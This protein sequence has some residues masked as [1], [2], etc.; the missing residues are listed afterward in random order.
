MGTQYKELKEKDKLFI[1]KQK[2]FYVASSSGQEVNLSPK[3]Y[4]SI[5][6]LDSKT[7]LYLDFPGSG[8]RTGRD[9]ENDGE[10]T[11]V[12]NSFEESEAHILRIF[13]K[14]EII[15]LENSRFSEFVEKFETKSKYIRQFMIFNIYAVETSC[16][17]SVPIMRFERTRTALFDWVKNI[18]SQGTL[19]E[20]IKTHK[21][22]PTL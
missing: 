12:F 9:I 14:G 17:E 2:L 16:G 15:N 7:I 19:L 5:R 4:D 18:E 8:N 20:Y 11:L 13:A 3:G 6:V 22:P 21:N 1:A 10:I